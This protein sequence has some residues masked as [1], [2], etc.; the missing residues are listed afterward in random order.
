M[1]SLEKMSAAEHRNEVEQSD[2]DES[3]EAI[4]NVE[5]VSEENSYSKKESM[6]CY[7]AANVSGVKKIIVEWWVYG[8]I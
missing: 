3:D 5:E 1:K 6:F 7:F 8:E 2:A 4:I